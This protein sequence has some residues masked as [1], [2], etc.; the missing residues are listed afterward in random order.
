VNGEMLNVVIE[1][2]FI[3]LDE[4]ELTIITA[5]KTNDFKITNGQYVL[6]LFPD[7]GSILKK[8]ESNKLTLVLEV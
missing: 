6:E 4:Y 7:N 3:N 5:M 1:T 8:Q 2:H